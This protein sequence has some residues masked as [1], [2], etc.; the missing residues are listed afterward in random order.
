MCTILSNII[1]YF[2]EK[3]VFTFS[4]FKIR[5]KLC[6]LYSRMVLKAKQDK[7]R[8]RLNYEYV[9]FNECILFDTCLSHG[10]DWQLL[11]SNG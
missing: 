2:R 9:F 11:K 6:F 5:H 8:I 7:Q 4:M 1:S 3:I 10:L